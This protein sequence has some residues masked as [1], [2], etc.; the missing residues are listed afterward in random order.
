MTNYI[1]PSQLNKEWF[2]QLPLQK[3]KRGNQGNNK[4]VYYKEIICAFDIETSRIPEIE[5][6]IMYV[7][8]LQ[9][10]LDT[11]IIGREWHEFTDLLQTMSS[12]LEENEYIVLF[13]HNLSYEFQFLRGIYDFQ[14]HEVFA[15]KS[16]SVLKC[17]MYDHIEFRCSYIH[18]NMGLDAFT[19]KFGVENAKLD[20]QAFNYNKVR[21]PWTTLTDNE[22]QYCINDVKG[23]VQAIT[24]EMEHD[25]DNLYSYPLTNTGYVRRD[26]KHAMRE[27]S[28]TFVKNQLPDLET[29][30][31]CRESFRGG[32]THANRYYAN[33]VLK[34]VKS[35]DRVSSYPDVICNCKFPVSKFIHIG[36]VSFD[37]LLDLVNVRKKAVLMRISMTNVRLS[38]QFFG[39][40]Y[41]P[42]D[43]CRNVHNAVIDNG[44]IISADY[45][46]MTITDIDLKIILM[47]YDFDDLAPYDVS[48]ARYGMLPKPLVNAVIEYFRLKT[49]LKNVEGS[50]L[51]YNKAKEKINAIYGM[52]AQDP[53]KQ[54]IIF[55]DGDFI[56]EHE[57]IL[58]LLLASNKKAFLCYQWGVWTTAWAR[59][60]LEEGIHLSGEGFVYTDT[61]SVKYIGDVDWTSFNDKR[62]A[63]SKASGA[64]ATDKFGHTHY[65]GIFEMETTEQGYEE[66]ITLGAKK[67]CYRK[68][69]QLVT[70]I[71]GVSKK[72]GGKELEKMGGI[73]Y[74]KQ[75]TKFVESGGLQAIYND[76]PEITSYTIDGH[77]IN[78]TSN[79]V[80]KPSIYTLGISAEYEKILNFSK[81]EL[82]NVLGMV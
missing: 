62:T 75:N 32:N 82:D 22:L 79:V 47:E 69:G 81:K 60:R 53:I 7:W 13:V 70:T 25:N 11:T 12:M 34:N 42:K 33:I 73:E 43:K 45:L 1:F 24:I 3:R 46:E 50:E 80:L 15:L 35:A 61:D 9:L 4:K 14:Q 56:E 28:H 77:T 8:Q 55:M 72:S 41:I 40:P 44:R 64:Y 18:A 71:A 37:E 5:Q 54:N 39:C 26:V 78:I 16:R 49:E 76:K 68:D 10:G 38:N 65:M 29:Y 6:S 63:E 20:G 74:F 30:K 58:N 66:F 48:H 59:Y 19:K 67:Y 27:I 2:N 17:T 36:A 21:F 31:K 51:L 23:L 52:M 57:D